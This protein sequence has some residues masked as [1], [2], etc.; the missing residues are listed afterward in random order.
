MSSYFG[1]FNLAGRDLKFYLSIVSPARYLLL[2]LDYLIQ[3]A[4]CK[5]AY[6]ILTF[7]IVAICFLVMLTILLSAKFLQ[8]INA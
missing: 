8:S 5:H 7:L 2:K 1:T 3:S 6:R 4:H